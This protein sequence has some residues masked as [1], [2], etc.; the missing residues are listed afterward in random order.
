L[1][2]NNPAFGLAAVP[3]EMKNDKNDP[4]WNDAAALG[5]P[6][7]PAAAAPGTA[8]ANNA[9]GAGGENTDPPADTTGAD[10]TTEPDPDTAAGPGTTTPEDP[11]APEEPA[12]P[13]TVRART[14]DPTDDRTAPPRRTDDSDPDP[15]SA[16]DSTATADRPRLPDFPASTSRDADTPASSPPSATATGADTNAAPTPNVNAPA[17][18]H[19]YGTTTRRDT[20]R[21]RPRPADTASLPAAAIRGKPSRPSEMLV[22]LIM[23]ETFPGEAIC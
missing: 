14:P 4:G 12:D 15:E 10:L 16:D 7:E 9:V 5:A 3:S 2:N 21:C 11:T 20:R 1:P 22:C 13:V 23:S 19:P 17:P 8:A 18:N 6:T